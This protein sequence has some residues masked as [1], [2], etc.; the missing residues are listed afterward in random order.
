MDYFRSPNMILIVSVVWI[1]K[2]SKPN[3]AVKIGNSLIGTKDIYFKLNWRDS[4]IEIDFFFWY[5]VPLK[6]L[7]KNYFKNIFSIKSFSPLNTSI[8][9]SLLY[10]NL[11]FYNIEL[12]VTMRVLRNTYK[13]AFLKLAAI[14]YFHH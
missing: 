12:F 4:A 1:Q 2:N 10:A 6:K 11:Q 13:R 7:W 9:I 8:C 14:I 3:G 5:V